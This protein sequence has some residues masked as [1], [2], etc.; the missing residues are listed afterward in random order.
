MAARDTLIRLLTPLYREAVHSPWTG[1]SALRAHTGVSSAYALGEEDDVAASDDSPVLVIGGFMSHPYYYAPFARMLRRAGYSVHIDD[2]FNCRRFIP[3][4]ERLCKRVDEIAAATGRPVRIVGHSLGGLQ[5]FAVL[6]QCPDAIGQV[7]AVASPIL[8]GTPWRPL[9][10]LAERVLG[11][12][13]RDSR[14]LYEQIE[15]YANRVTT[16]SSPRDLIAPPRVCAIAGAGN[17]VL[18]TITSADRALASH[19]GVIFMPTA[20]RVILRSLLR[21]CPFP[22]S[23]Q[24]AI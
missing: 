9:Q 23:V 4:V 10:Q 16:I 17:V 11:V 1:L 3:Y 5:A 19:T 20:V 18:S 2:L 13:A 22:M 7:V 14:V 24:H 6:A 8:G 21:P 15:P 12:R